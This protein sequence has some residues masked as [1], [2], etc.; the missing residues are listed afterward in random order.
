MTTSSKVTWT[1]TLRKPEELVTRRTVAVTSEAAA[2]LVSRPTPTRMA[3]SKTA[4]SLAESVGTSPMVSHRGARQ[5]ADPRSPRPTVQPRAEIGR[6][7]SELQSRGH[8]VCRLLLEKKKTQDA[9]R[10]DA[11][12]DDR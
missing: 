5:P 9:E 10:H 8:L 12:E 7:H 11:R 4:W 3:R 6:A 1:D 2:P